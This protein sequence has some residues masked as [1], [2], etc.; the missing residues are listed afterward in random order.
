LNIIRLPALLGMFFLLSSCTC[1]TPMKVSSIQKSDKKLTCKDIIL[2]INEA[3]HFREEGLKEKSISAGEALMP[4]CWLSGYLD[5]NKAAK[6]ANSRIEYLGQIYE[7]MD[8][9]GAGDKAASQQTQPIAIPVAPA[10]PAITPQPLIQPKNTENTDAHYKEKNNLG[11]NQMH[12]HMDKN[13]R[14][15]IHSHPHDGPHRHLEDE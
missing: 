1:G 13:G 12:E 8:C 7:L 10:S 9:G 15:Y 2:E 11:Q 5:G 3:E 6:Q 4:T 14:V